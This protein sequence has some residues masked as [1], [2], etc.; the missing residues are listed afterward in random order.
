MGEAQVD[1]RWQP[2]R[3]RR[4]DGTRRVVRIRYMSSN[5]FITVEPIGSGGWIRTMTLSNLYKK[6]ELVAE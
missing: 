4:V 1:Q 5:G 2:K 6:Y 3:S